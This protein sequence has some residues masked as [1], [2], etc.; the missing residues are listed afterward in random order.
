MTELS[1]RADQ[2]RP[3]RVPGVEARA[4]R[5]PGPSLIPALNAIQER[6][7]WLPREELEELARDTRRP[8]YEIEGLVSFYPHFRTSPPAKVA[9][10]VCRDLTCWLHA[11]AERIA[12]LR[13]R[14][15]DD[16]DVE[17][18][19]VSCLGRCD[20]APAAAVNEHPATVSALD[21]LDALVAAAREA[22]VGHAE[23]T[24]SGRTQPWPND[25]YPAGSGVAQRYA[26]LRALLG[27]QLDPDDVVAVLAES[28]LRGMGGAGFPTGKKWELVRAAEPGGVKYAICN[29]D[30]SEPGTFKD[31]QILADQPHLVLEGLLLGMAV[32]GAEQGWVFIRH[33]YGPE[34]RVLRAELAA[35]RAAGVVG[36]D[37]CGSGRRLE[38]DIFTSPG[39]YILGEETALIECMEGHRGEPRNKPPFPGTYG[40]HG[41]PTLMNSVE[42][43]ADV[44]VILTRG[45]QWWRDQGRGQA[46]GW[47]FFAV[48][49]HVQR[50]GVYCVPMGTTVRELI[51]RA[52]GVSGGAGVGAVQPGGASSN[53]I[54]PDQ[55]DLPLD[56]APLAEAGTM[57]GSGA[58]VVLAEGTD[59]LTAATNVLRFFRNES[60]GKCVPCRVGST[61]AHELLTGVLAA[62][63]SRLDEAQ[64]ARVLQLE[65]AMRKTSIC[66]LGQVALGP[67][68][69]VL[70]LDKGGASARPQPRPD[71]A[72]EQPTR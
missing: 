55:L 21:A 36:P 10:S 43:F 65:E 40:L 47:K 51:A 57:L 9:L 16:A 46:V 19:E 39:G 14:Y 20:I 24:A 41:R 17:L 56:F 29:A 7:G 45:A 8:R 52:G 48:S 71:G 22:G 72:P 32:V 6:M 42:T 66:G 54:G 68:V 33:E 58:L 67:V 5:F 64:H 27:G 61:K 23:P 44:P 28:G 37:A 63:S 34:E 12:A 35:L 1:E 49:G 4:G 15:G 30:E 25:P 11:G 38:V 3:R 2:V 53:F 18:V 59:L 60:C 31:R 70:G 62:G 50:A 26:T 13:Q 69:S